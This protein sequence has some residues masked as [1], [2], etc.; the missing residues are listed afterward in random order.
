ESGRYCSTRPEHGQGA[1]GAAVMVEMR[2]LEPLTPSLQ[3]RCSPSLATSP[4]TLIVAPPRRRRSRRRQPPAWL[5][6]QLLAT[7]P[8]DLAGDPDRRPLALLGERIVRTH[9]RH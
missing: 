1:A 7:R 5:G 6:R 8:G 2:G 9:A 4:L 3:R